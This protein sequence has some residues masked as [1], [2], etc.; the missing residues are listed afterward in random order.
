MSNNTK[1]DIDA[2]QVDPGPDGDEFAVGTSP[3]DVSSIGG[4]PVRVVIAVGAGTVKYTT[5]GSNGTVRTATLADR[6]VLGP[7]QIKSI[8][9]S[10]GG[11]TA[12][13]LRVIK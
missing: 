6:E 5:A 9:G 2:N 7:L 11:T 12:P 3:L 13:V 4:Y 8:L 1:T 10:S